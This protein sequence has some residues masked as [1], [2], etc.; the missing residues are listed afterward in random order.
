[1]EK[2]AKPGASRFEVKCARCGKPLI[3]PAVEI[4]A[5]AGPIAFGPK[6]AKAA[7]LHNKH[8]PRQSE[9]VPTLEGQLELFATM[10]A[11][12]P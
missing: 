12:Q 2:R 8:K 1:M 7:G 11:Q 9:A 5:R 4:P 6:C 3:R 10:E